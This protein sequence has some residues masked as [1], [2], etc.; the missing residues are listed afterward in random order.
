MDA[1]KRMRER[2]RAGDSSTAMDELVKLTE[3]GIHPD[4]TAVSTCLSACAKAGDDERADA[5]FKEVFE[6]GGGILEPNEMSFALLI[7]AHLNRQSPNWAK[8][9]RL[10]GAM[11]HHFAINPTATTCGNDFP[12]SFHLPP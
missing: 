1:T 12:S 3:Q 6:E 2:A 8:A 9:A 11:R 10:M 7:K 5:I 4:I